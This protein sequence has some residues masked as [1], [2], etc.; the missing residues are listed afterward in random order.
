MAKKA[1]VCPRCG[2]T[3]VILDPMEPRIDLY[4]KMPL[5][6]PKCPDTDPLKGRRLWKTLTKSK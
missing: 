6:C 1:F 5:K 4:K 3:K 2:D